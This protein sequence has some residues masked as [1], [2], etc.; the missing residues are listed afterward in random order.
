MS[1]RN[2]Q[3]VVTLIAIFAT[4][5]R[6]DSLRLLPIK[7]TVTAG[8]RPHFTL[9][10]TNDTSAAERFIDVRRGRRTDLRDNLYRLFVAGKNGKEIDLPQAISD[11]GP[12][13]ESD[14]FVLGPSKSA[15]ID[16]PNSPHQLQELPPGKY[17]AWVEYRHWEY[18]NG[19]RP[20]VKSSIGTFSVRPKRK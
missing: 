3:V 6:A 12:I 18:P 7:Q 20:T 13:D 4:T 17:T 8:T 5:S 2:L 15:E 19:S 14:Y 1:T 10:I 9:Q 16:L 11:P